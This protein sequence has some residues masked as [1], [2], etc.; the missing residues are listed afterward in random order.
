MGENICKS[1]I[2]KACVYSIYKSSLCYATSLQ[3]CL[4]L[5][6]P[7][8]CRP[9]GCSVHG[10]LQA[11]IVEWVAMPSSRESAPPRDRTLVSYVS[12]TGRWVLVPIPGEPIYLFIMCNCFILL[13]SLLKN[14]PFW[15]P[16]AYCP[17]LCWLHHGPALSLLY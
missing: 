12:C 16:S 7:I 8:D 4:T 6:D 1:C 11:R 10:I 9:P 13:F 14:F 5:C 2:Y 17:K 3:S 15:T